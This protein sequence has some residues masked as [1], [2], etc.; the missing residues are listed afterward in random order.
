MQP[1][2]QHRHKRR[3]H[4]AMPKRYLAFA[5]A[6]TALALA[7]CNNGDVN[8]LFG[9]ATPTPIPTSTASP[10]PDP[11]ASTAVV[12][13]YYSSS[14]LPN[15]TV[16]LSTSV[17]GSVGTPL[18]TQTTAPFSNASPGPGKAVFSN[19]TPTVTYCFSATF[20]PTPGPSSTPGPTPLPRTQYDC[21]PYWGT[22]GVTLSF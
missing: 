14:P 9:S 11:S 22:V 3:S 4:R 12:S 10:S 20:Q 2:R 18:A 1:A 21:T 6:A 16:T 15:Q 5:F 17:N 19:L 7:A 13:V 8:D